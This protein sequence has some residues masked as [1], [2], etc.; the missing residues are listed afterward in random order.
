MIHL[1][2]VLVK[3]AECMVL[4]EVMKHVEPEDTQFGSSGK[5]CTH[6]A[7]A[8]VYEFLK[9]HKGYCSALLSMDVEEGFNRINIDL[10]ADFLS[11]R[12]C[13]FALVEW[14]RH[15]A[16]QHRIQFRFKGRLSRLFHLGR[17]IPQGSPLSSF[18][19]GAYAADVFGLRLRYSR[20]V[21]SVNV[22]YV[23]DRIVALAGESVRV[24]KVWL[25][26]VFEDC[27]RMAQGRSMGFS[28]LET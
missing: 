28:G 22:N 17:S 2:L 19:F 8:V 1:L 3:V 23:D 15:W 10:I 21:R 26:E 25:K 7:C 24:V 6:D 12:G 27:S 14:I 16:S 18:L 9:H 20:T 11:T 4:L 13:L 5:R